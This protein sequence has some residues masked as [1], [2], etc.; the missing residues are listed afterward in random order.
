MERAKFDDFHFH[1][2]RHRFAS[3]FMM[4]GGVLLALS[5]ILGQKQ[6]SMT[7]KYAHLAPDHLRAES[8]GLWVPWNH[9]LEPTAQHAMRPRRK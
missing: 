4:R 5:R 3:W 9:L 6:V 7:E 8:P 1:D 2:L